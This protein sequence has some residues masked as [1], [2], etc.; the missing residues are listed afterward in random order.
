MAARAD[1]A[2]HRGGTHSPSEFGTVSVPS[3]ASPRPSGLRKPVA[4]TSTDRPS[5]EIRNRPCLLDAV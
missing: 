1:L 3:G 5:A 2:D 4:T